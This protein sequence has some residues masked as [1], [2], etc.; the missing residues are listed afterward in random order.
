MGKARG[1]RKDRRVGKE[2]ARILLR[3]AVGGTMIAHGVRHARTLGGTAGWF[4]SLGFRE[5]KVQAVTSAVVETGAGAALVAGAGTPIAAAG[6]VGTMGV[7]GRVVHM[8]NGFFITAEGY[9]YVLNLA[10]SSVALA[11]LGPGRF[12]VDHA[13]GL[14]RLKIA[15]G[16]RAAA[17]TAGLGVGAVVAHLVAFWRPEPPKPDE[18]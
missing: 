4:G 6:V 15:R 12:S 18:S 16:W 9:E 17:L 10:A 3:A 11:A 1:K 5:P 8:P 13:L 7:A 14:D 2:V